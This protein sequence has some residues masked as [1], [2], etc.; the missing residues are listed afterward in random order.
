[1]KSKTLLIALCMGLIRN[2]SASSEVQ[3]QADKI[4]IERMMKEKM[5]GLEKHRSGKFTA[6]PQQRADVLVKTAYEKM[7]ADGNEGAAFKFFEDALNLFPYHTDALLSTGLKLLQKGNKDEQRLGV[8]R[9]GYS[10]ADDAHP[11]PVDVDSLQGAML[12]SMIGNWY[13]KQN[14]Y[15][16]ARKFF[17]HAASSEA[18]ASHCSSISS[19]TMLTSYPESIEDMEI[20]F[21]RSSRL[22]E[23]LINVKSLSMKAVPDPDYFNFCF[24]PSQNYASYQNEDIKEIMDKYYRVALKAFPEH[25]YVAPFIK[26]ER[27]SNKKIKI[28]LVSSYFDDKSEAVSLGRTLSQLSKNEYDVSF[29]WVMDDKEQK[30]PFLNEA[31]DEGFEVIKVR[32]EA[33]PPEKW[34]TKAH[35]KIGKY[36][37][38]V[39]LYPDIS[40]SKQT[41]ALGMSRLARVQ[42]TTH[43][44]PTT[45]GI[46]REV[47]D[48]FISWEATELSEKE[49][50]AHYTEELLMFS[51]TEFPFLLSEG[52]DENTYGAITRE[53]VAEKLE[54]PE[55]GNWYISLQPSGKRTPQFD[56]II[57]DIQM[58]D[59]QA[60]IVLLEDIDN[61]ES[62]KIIHGRFQASGCDLSR[63]HFIAPQDETQSL[64]LLN[65]A[66]VVMDPYMFSNPMQTKQ[67][68]DVGSAII[69]LPTDYHS[70]RW[71]KAYLEKLGITDTIANDDADFVKKAVH[72]ATKKGEGKK[73]KKNIKK[74]LNKFYKNKGAVESW[75]LMIMKLLSKYPMGSDEL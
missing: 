10:F 47:M 29:I 35:E 74:S 40:R 64:A 33:D 13:M 68:L 52:P 55:E 58:K 70:G 1:M 60:Q 7:T 21:D 2:S 16:A 71:T 14:E 45:S 42:A 8:T 41:Y 17:K 56:E 30:T 57:S 69:T 38:D 75:D 6:T 37:L 31:K 24:A 66:D 53:E 46:S 20:A 15:K 32:T 36:E 51:Q 63:I 73:L 48:Y 3:R 23:K 5:E 26:E 28:G 18:Q 4:R 49:A 27:D 19:A 67:A 54:I 65:L 44:N 12:S 34:V 62:K 9:L 59:A 72:F 43:G 50:Q 22:M 11:R 61:K 39:I 25:G